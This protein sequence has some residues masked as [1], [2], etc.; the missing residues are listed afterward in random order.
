M[1]Q[2]LPAFGEST[3]HEV[4]AKFASELVSS[5]TTAS[6]EAI[7]IAL[8]GD[9]GA[10]KTTFAKECAKVLGI[11]TETV[12]SPTF[13]IEKIYNISYKGFTRFIHI[14]AYRLTAPRELEVLGWN[15]IVGNPENIVMI[16]WPENVSELIPATAIKIAI[17]H[18]DENS[19]IF[20]LK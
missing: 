12:T 3:S 13:V 7:V 19:R 16:E 17:D 5:L 8:Y 2:P 9:L 4:T 15:E 20:T 14:D 11:E 6:N 1:A 10:G 18:K